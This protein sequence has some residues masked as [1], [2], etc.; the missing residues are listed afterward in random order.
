MRGLPLT[1]AA[2]EFAWERHAGQRR[3]ADG[4]LFVLHPLEVASLLERSDYPDHVVAAAV[5]HDVLEDT[6]A[7]RWELE[8]RFGPDVSALVAV[9]SD[10]LS[11]PDEDDRRD[12]VRERVRRAGGYAPVVYAAD[13]VSKVRELRILLLTGFTQEK[14]NSKGDHYRKCLA[15]LEETIPES[16][17]V[18][19]LRFEL[20]VLE[21]LP[22]QGMPDG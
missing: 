10:D 15:M 3:L 17:I 9:V 6:D 4:A 7:E 14:A 2:V 1:Q 5:L 12:D 16:R 13:K 20:E 18:E 22:P 8:T 11:I 21:K 19:L